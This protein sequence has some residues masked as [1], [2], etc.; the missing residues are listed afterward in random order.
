MQLCE[1][2]DSIKSLNDIEATKLGLNGNLLTAR[3]S[4]GNRGLAAEEGFTGLHMAIDCHR[5]LRKAF[6]V[7]NIRGD[8][9]VYVL[10]PADHSPGVNGQPTY[11]HELDTCLREPAKELIEGRFGQCGRAA[12]TNCIS[13]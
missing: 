13:L 1:S 10:C 12:P 5:N 11:Q 6:E 9:D 2:R 3:Q 4:A 7:L 8:N